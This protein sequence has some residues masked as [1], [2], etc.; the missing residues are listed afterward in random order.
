LTD[1]SVLLC[2]GWAAAR[3]EL[4]RFVEAGLTKFVVRPA[5]PV[6]SRREFLTE[7]TNELDPLQT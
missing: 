2:R 1:P 6:T 5:G 4:T 3:A 7:F